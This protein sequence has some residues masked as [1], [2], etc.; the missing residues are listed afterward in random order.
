MFFADGTVARR[1][2]LNKATAAL[3]YA[4]AQEKLRPGTTAVL[5]I[6]GGH[7][8]FVGANS[9]MTRASGL[10]MQEPLTAVDLDALEEFFRSHGAMPRLELCPLADPSLLALTQERGYK[11]HHFRNVLVRSLRPSEMLPE[12]S[13]SVSV[14]RA[15]S[16]AEKELWR[17]TVSRGFAGRDDVGPEADQIA[18]PITAVPAVACYLAWQGEEPIGA[19]AMAIRGGLAYLSSTSVRPAFRER[20]AQSA[21]LWVRLTDA[22]E[23]GCDLVMVETTPGSGSQRNLERFG[24]RVVYTTMAV[25]KDG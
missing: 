24:F 14:T 25:Y 23:A 18:L 9:P 11:I 21:L 6:A 8:V 10:G 20:G 2:E 19:G 4:R 22:I 7:A 12:P 16:P 15:V 17:L 1:L 3:E 5:S 13:T